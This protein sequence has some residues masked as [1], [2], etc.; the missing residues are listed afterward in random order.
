MSNNGP[1][2]HLHKHVYL[3]VHCLMPMRFIGRGQSLSNSWIVR[4]IALLALGCCF[5][6]HKVDIIK[7]G[8]HRVECLVGVVGNIVA[9]NA[10]CQRNQVSG[11]EQSARKFEIALG[12]GST[13]VEVFE[14]F[15]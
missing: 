8:S 6:R 13:D 1:G 15:P 14:L 11:Q 4:V 2:A 9:S 7:R 12:V 5:V 3:L 10:R